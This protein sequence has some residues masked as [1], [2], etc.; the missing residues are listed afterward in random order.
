M[1]TT[2]RNKVGPLSK[3]GRFIHYFYIILSQYFI[4][5]FMFTTLFINIGPVYMSNS[6]HFSSKLS[7][8][9]LHNLN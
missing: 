1:V 7:K 8:L 9:L 5:I 2:L 6:Q 4:K 3:V